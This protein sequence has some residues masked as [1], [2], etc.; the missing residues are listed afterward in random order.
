MSEGGNQM[1]Q[2]L[3]AGTRTPGHPILVLVIMGV[4]SS[5][6][7]L[8]SPI[9][10]QAQLQ[11]AIPDSVACGACSIQMQRVATIG[12][13]DGAGA[14]SDQ[15]TVRRMPDGQYLVTDHLASGEIRL[16]DGTGTFVRMVARSGSGPG[17]FLR[18]GPFLFTGDSTIIF[19][20]QQGRL[21]VMTPE[22]R[23]FRSMAF[24]YRPGDIVVLSERL[25]VMS[26]NVA[27]ADRIGQPLHVVAGGELQGSFGGGAPQ[28][29][30]SATMLLQRSLAPAGVDRVLA[31]PMNEYL[32]EEWSIVGQQLAT[33]RRLVAWFTPWTNPIPPFA[34]PPQPY[35]AA[36]RYDPARH[37][38]WVLLHVT[39]SNWRGTDLRAGG[40]DEMF[41]MHVYYD[42]VIEVIDLNNRHLV[43]RLAYDD[44]IA[45]F[46]S[47][48]HT[49]VFTL[50]DAGGG[51]PVYDVWRLTIRE[52]GF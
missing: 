42:T 13:V 2:I 32:I 10:A 49:H 18:P 45:G 36:L 1:N 4:C 28:V 44:Y 17:E 24:P 20:S 46:A 48:D 5:A 39:G 41:N 12:D 34:A 16:F 3:P 35:I 38:L 22:L 8:L 14:L 21:T 37:H 30:P 23:S 31:A 19:D 47:Q 25:W 15:A 43:T 26:A 7:G 11:Y 29:G 6:A 50:R 52:A 9:P 40:R 33:Y 27:T 51:V